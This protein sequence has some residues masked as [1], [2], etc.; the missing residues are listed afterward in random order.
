[1]RPRYL[2]WT[3]Q[4]PCHGGVPDQPN[5]LIRNMR[6]SRTVKQK[7][8][9][10]REPGSCVK[11]AEKHGIAPS[12]VCR[13]RQAISRLRRTKRSRRHVGGGRN[14]KFPAEE[15]LLDGWITTNRRLCRVLDAKTICAKMLKLVKQHHRNTTF[16]ASLSWYHGFLRR[17]G[18]SSRKITSFTTARQTKRE[19]QEFGS[20]EGHQSQSRASIELYR[21]KEFRVQLLRLLTAHHY[22]P[23]CIF[24]MDET[25]FYLD[26]IPQRTVEKIGTRRIVAAET[27]GSGHQFRRA[28]AMLTVS[29]DGTKRFLGV[30]GY[31]PKKKSLRRIRTDVAVW[32][33]PSSSVDTKLL[34]EFLD[35]IL[36]PQHCTMGRKL[37]II[38]K[39]PTHATMAV[40]QACLRNGFD[41]V[42]IPA[43][44]TKYVQPIDLAVNH[45]F[46]AKS[47]QQW[48][49]RQWTRTKR[50]D[51]RDD[52]LRTFVTQAIEAWDAVSEDTVRNGFKSMAQFLNLNLDWFGL[53]EASQ[54]RLGRHLT[55]EGL[56]KQAM[57]SSPLIRQ[58]PKER[59]PVP[60]RKPYQQRC[61]RT[62]T[63][64]NKLQSISKV[65][66][67]MHCYPSTVRK[68]LQRINHPEL[69][70]PPGRRR[71][72]KYSDQQCMEMKQWYNNGM[73][74][75]QVCERFN[76]KYA[77]T[78]LPQPSLCHILQRLA[79]VQGHD[80]PMRMEMNRAQYVKLTLKVGLPY[81]HEIPRAM[82]ELLIFR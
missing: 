31:Y 55:L 69:C 7:L 78:R 25:S 68:R 56:E 63:L 46:K 23:E 42:F 43:G 32:T 39:A 64:W 9:I 4:L 14:A 36:G 24:N 81:K 51:T 74:Q 6:T 37:L 18:Y 3:A 19:V 80:L 26:M 10:A 65:A 50:I 60:I 34:V 49:E 27:Y 61:E 38:D 35:E 15:A 33:Q 41:V 40:R 48:V 28:S 29:A 73:T 11:V 2:T 54:R 72:R 44:C 45:S 5:H 12:M 1:M 57:A 62:L 47:R 67:T 16:K 52:V 58:E 59:G 66:R 17:F 77:P 13:W 53:P 20:L 21:L 75:E 8:L 79:A 70:K 22:S 76:R 71:P 82:V 30:V